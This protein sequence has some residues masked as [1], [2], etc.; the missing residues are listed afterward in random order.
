MLFCYILAHQPLV[1]QGLL[2]HKVTYYRHTK[3]GRT[4][5]DELSA[6]RRTLLSDNTQ[7]DKH[8]RWDSNPQSQQASGLRPHCHWGYVVFGCQK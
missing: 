7:H 5:W 2:I 3:V 4:L 6:R 1:G 8:P